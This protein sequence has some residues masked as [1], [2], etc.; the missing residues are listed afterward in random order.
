MILVL[1]IFLIYA[2]LK[3]ISFVFK[4]LIYVFKFISQ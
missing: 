4:F 1:E 3:N 2:P